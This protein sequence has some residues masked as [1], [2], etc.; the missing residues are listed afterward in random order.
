LLFQR[1]QPFTF[2]RRV[3][4]NG[5]V[6]RFQRIH[7]RLHFGLQ[8]GLDHGLIEQLTGVFGDI[9]EDADDRERSHIRR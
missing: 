1:S 2:E 3:G 5:L 7:V 6:H 8:F 4:V 9:L